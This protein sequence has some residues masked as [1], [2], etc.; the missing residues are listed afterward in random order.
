MR[1][2]LGSFK[3]GIHTCGSVLMWFDDFLR[4]FTQYAPFSSSLYNNQ[5][6]LLLWLDWTRW[7]DYHEV[8]YIQWVQW[9]QEISIRYSFI[10]PKKGFHV[11]CIGWIWYISPRAALLT[12]GNN[13]TAHPTWVFFHFF[14]QRISR[15]CH[16]SKV[17]FLTKT[18]WIA[19]W[20]QLLVPDK[21]TKD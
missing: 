10:Q 3:G 17:K 13:N 18:A 11:L 20:L 12:A 2:K 21:S 19:N 16:C 4:Y 6:W 14:F 8:M 15:I 9:I 7:I 5:V 1:F